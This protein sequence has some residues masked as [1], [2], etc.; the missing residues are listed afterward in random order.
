MQADVPHPGREPEKPALVV[1][2]TLFPSAAEP[3][4][5][6][7]IKERMFRVARHL[8]I[9]VIS[10]QPW[11]PLQGLIRRWKPTYRP[12]KLRDEV[13]D[14]IRVYRP[15]F[16]AIPGLLRRLDGWSIAL[17]S[18]PLLRRLLAAGQA[19]ILDVHFG[20]PDG[21]AGHL[22]ARWSGLPYVITL[23]GKEERLR[24]QRPIGN[25]MAIAL[26]KADKVVGVSSALRQ[27]AVDLGAGVA[28]AVLIGNGIDLDKFRPIAQEQARLRLGIAADAEVM[29]SVGSL[30]E[31]KGFHR[32]IECMPTLLRT[33]PRLLFLV[34]GGPGPEGDDSQRLQALTRDLGLESKVRFLGP[35]APG[36]L[37]VPLSAADVF[38]LATRYEGWANVLLEAMACRLP[39]VTTDVGGNA[40]VVCR[41]E[42]G[43]LVPFGDASALTRAIG[44]ALERDWNRDA[45]R[46]Y[47]QDN[48]W[49][50]RIAQV[51]ALMRD[52]HRQARDRTG[53]TPRESGISLR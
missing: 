39:V 29:V 51:V 31:R 17:A 49:D 30:V 25:R 35:M 32:V 50:K 4:A 44:T 12:D 13:V 7:F 1:L 6:V 43:A 18:W 45:I 19:D 34:V 42:L 14:G 20:F 48:T 27:V 38:V 2:S 26:R 47:A 37:H 9:V 15:R 40:E 21:H 10:P 28:D 41:D 16:F 52:V 53:M 46:A 3:V 5:G 23:R 11:F 8:P 36:E 22:L 24:S 33:H